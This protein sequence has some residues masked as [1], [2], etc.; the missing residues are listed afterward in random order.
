ME[1]IVLSKKR[2]ESLE[3][4]ELNKKI[5]NSEGKLYKFSEKRNWIKSPKLLKK[6][7]INEGETFGNKLATLTSLIC[8]KEE[9]S[10]LDIILPEKFV[11]VNKELSAFTMPYIENQNFAVILNDKSIP[12]NK[13]IEYFKQIGVLFESLH[14]FRKYSEIKDF[15][16]NDVHEGNF[17]V[18]KST[19][20]IK[21]V[22]VDS[23]RINGNKPFPTKYLNWIYIHANLDG[24]YTPYSPEREKYYA[25]E[26]SDL[27]CYCIM[28]LNFF[29]GD[30]FYK[31]SLP[32]FYTYLQYLEDIKFP[33]PLLEIFAK[34]Y[35]FDNN[36][37]PYEYLDELPKDFI[38]AHKSVYSRVRKK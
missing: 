10:S 22:D 21:A 35:T 28:L 11:V 25:N 30:K 33:K 16:L 36:E 23:C 4:L 15:F 24:K 18:E 2:F 3:P 17:I 34:L 13:K 14:N 1:T 37:N 7:Y 9:L 26:N 27:F 5:C 32:E 29:Y 12:L 38:R 31:L 20:R 8:N 19:D 6:L